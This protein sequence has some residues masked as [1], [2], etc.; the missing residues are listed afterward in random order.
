LKGSQL[1]ATETAVT[2][3]QARSAEMAIRAVLTGNTGR[4]SDSNTIFAGQVQG[5]TP[6]KNWMNLR[7]LIGLHRP[8]LNSIVRRD[9]GFTAICEG[10]PTPLERASNGRW[11]PARPLTALS[12]KRAG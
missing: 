11:T 3:I 9:S 4:H 2:N 12:E 6:N 1:S 5:G 8:L 10:C 7:C